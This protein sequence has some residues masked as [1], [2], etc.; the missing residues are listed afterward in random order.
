MSALPFRGGV[1]FRM[2]FPDSGF[3]TYVM[4]TAMVIYLKNVE[5]TCAK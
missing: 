5:I 3:G 1:V 2:L 4:L